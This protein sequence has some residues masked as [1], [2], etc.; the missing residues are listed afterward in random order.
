MA[1]SASQVK[2]LRERT[3]AGMMD[4]K[5]ALTETDGDVDAAIEWLRK[6]G[7][8]AAAK[9][10]T[11]TANEGAVFSYVHSN[12]AIGVLL[13]LS[14]ETDFVARTDD[15]QELGKELAMQ[16]AA[17]SPEFVSEDDV[18]VERIEREKSIL[19]ELTLNEGKPEQ[20]VPRIV[21]GRLRKALSEICLLNQ[22]WVRDEKRKK[23][24]GDLVAETAA[25]LG[26][27][28]KVR[29]FVRFDVGDADA[30]DAAEAE[31]SA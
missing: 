20:A 19:T 3:G 13:E 4:C 21:E 1:I 12:A 11:R 7:L 25:N 15:F 22:I 6:K 18:P 9:R 28:I 24:V 16:V 2:E 8:S 27:N 17:M 14:C 10:G 30:P 26:E 5:K 31:D 29:R 23:S